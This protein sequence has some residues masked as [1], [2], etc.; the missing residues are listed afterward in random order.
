M[1]NIK[2]PKKASTGGLVVKIGILCFG[3]LGLVPGCRSTPLMF[4][5]SKKRKI[6]SRCQLRVNLPQQKKKK[7]YQTEI[8]KLKNTITELKN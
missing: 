1:E 5:L 7:K 4:F 2:I 8:V 3:G 6:S